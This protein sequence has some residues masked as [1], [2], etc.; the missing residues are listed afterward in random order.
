MDG[1]IADI[2][3]RKKAE[4]DRARLLTSEQQARRTAEL[5]NRVGPAL[6]SELKVEK[7]AQTLVEIG[8]HLTGAL[9][10]ALFFVD[11]EAGAC[12]V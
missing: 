4:N 8:T 6:S 12:S 2:H 10:G 3:D 11:T 9:A 7:L 1:T 5:L